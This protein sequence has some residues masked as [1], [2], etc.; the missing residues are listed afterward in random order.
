MKRKNNK[1]EDGVLNILNSLLGNRPKV[2]INPDLIPRIAPSMTNEL[3]KTYQR[4]VDIRK[5]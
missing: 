1:T 3:I 4:K 5:R 2:V